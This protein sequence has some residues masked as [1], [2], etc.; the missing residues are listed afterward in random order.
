MRI[1][2]KEGGTYH[3]I[4]RTVQGR[5]LLE[6]REKAMFQKM[7]W[8][9]ADFSGLRIITYCLMSNHFHLLVE[10]PE[11]GAVDDAELVRRFQVLYPKP[12]RST[13]LR[14]EDLRRLLAD[15]GE[16]GKALRDGLLS[17]MGDLSIFMKAL[18]QRYSIW[19]NRTHETYGAFWAERF[20]S[21]I[22]EGRG[23]VLQVMAAYID[24]NPVRAGLVTDPKDYLFCG[25][26]EAVAG[27]QRA[28]YGV[29]RVMLAFNE[30]A[31]GYCPLAGYRAFLFD[32][33]SRAVEG[34][35]TISREHAQRV[36]E[37]AQGRLSLASVLRCKLR[38]FGSGMILGSADFVHQ[39]RKE[40][41]L[42]KTPSGRERKLGKVAIASL[43][44]LNLLGRGVRG[45]KS[46]G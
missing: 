15:N 29:E 30:A 35:A 17:R 26:A 11:A 39:L 34:K 45:L 7:L 44:G 28:L 2:K 1:I 5:S 10:V 36:I 19:Y 20:K 38:F 9:L 6:H 21:V 23:F 27:N 3:C 46:G 32:Q 8:Q 4:S 43:E 12:T 16:R 42:E 37:K 24:L 41:K 22:V 33:G 40:L 13:G 18:K 25:Y 14:A 31:A